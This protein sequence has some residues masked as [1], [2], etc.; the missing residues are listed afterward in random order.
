[1]Y[2]QL[3]QDESQNHEQQKFITHQHYQRGGDRLMAG[4]RNPK[5]GSGCPKWM[6]PNTSH[7]INLVLSS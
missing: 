1:M 5:N 7:V 6:V 2:S 4:G 3:F